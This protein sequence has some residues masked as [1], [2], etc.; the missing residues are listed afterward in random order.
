[1]AKNHTLK[2]YER[3]KSRKLITQLFEQGAHSFAYPLKLV[4][5]IEAEAELNQA[6]W[7]L[8][9]AVSIPKKKVKSAVDRNLLKRRIREAYRLNKNTL[10]SCLADNNLKLNLMFVY[11]E[12]EIKN[13]AVIENAVKQHLDEICHIIT[14]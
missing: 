3:L 14:D 10:Q 6:D 12:S 8:K 5:R 4:Y 1:M 2:D 9:F 7:L 11:L 13:Y